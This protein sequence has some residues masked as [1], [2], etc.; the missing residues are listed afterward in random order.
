[1]S[2][3]DDPRSAAARRG[4]VLFVSYL[5]LYAGFVGLTVFAPTWLMAR[6]GGVNLAVL[7]GFLLI[8]AAPVLAVVYVRLR[9][10][11]AE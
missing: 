5:V 6:I 7:Y 9:R 4:L 10:H 2:Q 3:G 11:E 1:M 8:V